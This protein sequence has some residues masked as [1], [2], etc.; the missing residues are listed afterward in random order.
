MSDALQQELTHILGRPL[1]ALMFT[2]RTDKGVNAGI[3]YATGWL[4][5]GPG[6]PDAGLQIAPQHQALGHHD[7]PV[8][9]NIRRTSRS[10]NLFLSI[11][12]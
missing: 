6:V 9:E 12:R 5:D 7:L 1:K 8:P 11:S 2:A 3:N 10:Q 4:K